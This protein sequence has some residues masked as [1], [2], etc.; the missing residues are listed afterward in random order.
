[1][2]E[3]AFNQWVEAAKARDWER[4]RN[5]LQAATENSDASKVASAGERSIA[6]N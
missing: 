2:N 1:M 6:Q 5:I 4:A 3:D